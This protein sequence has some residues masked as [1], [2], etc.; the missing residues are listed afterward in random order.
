MAL[1]VFLFTL[2]LHRL[3]ESAKV[4]NSPDLQNIL[5]GVFQSEF[6]SGV[7][8]CVFQYYES[9]KSSCKRII[10]QEQLVFAKSNFPE[11]MSP[12][13]CAYIYHRTGILE[14]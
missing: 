9:N 4:G 5:V 7:N 11:F 14:F 12:V 1:F 3:C 6:T 10:R 2:S 13:L 8:E